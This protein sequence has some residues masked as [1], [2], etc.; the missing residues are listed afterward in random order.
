M[1]T[2]VSFDY[3]IGSRVLIDKEV[4]GLVLGYWV[5]SGLVILYRV[6]WWVSGDCKAEWFPAWRVSA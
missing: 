3:E 2:V 5:D 1:P 6:S 4:S